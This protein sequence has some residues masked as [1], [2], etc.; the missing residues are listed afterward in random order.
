MMLPRCN[1]KRGEHDGAINAVKT[2][3]T[4]TDFATLCG[5]IEGLCE[6]RE[7]FHISPRFH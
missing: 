5:S 7:I 6:I 4:D 2:E 3:S 1:I